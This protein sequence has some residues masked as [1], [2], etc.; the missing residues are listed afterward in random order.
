MAGPI[1]GREVVI[2]IKRD[3]DTYAYIHGQTNAGLQGQA[4]EID[5]SSKDSTES[6]FLAGRSSETLS[7][8]ALYIP[9]DPDQALLK[10]AKRL[11]QPVTLM[12][13]ELGED[14]ES[15]TA[16][17]TGHN[18][19]FPDNAPATIQVTFRIASPWIGV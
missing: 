18:E 9:G 13:S 16:I 5:A 1:N 8:D 4:A 6:V 12:R 15:A 3:D 17:I 19:N 2:K 7:V 10:R 11:A 14:I